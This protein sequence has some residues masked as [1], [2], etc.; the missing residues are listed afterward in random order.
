MIATAEKSFL[1]IETRRARSKVFDQTLCALS[2][3]VVKSVFF[4]Q[5]Y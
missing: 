3:C 5:R 1:N 2:A 4:L